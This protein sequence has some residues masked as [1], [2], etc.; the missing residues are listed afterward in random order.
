MYVTL[1]NQEGGVYCVGC[2]HL[3]VHEPVLRLTISI[4]IYNESL[5]F[6]DLYIFV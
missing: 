5:L 6:L 1:E 3:P 4:V 2:F